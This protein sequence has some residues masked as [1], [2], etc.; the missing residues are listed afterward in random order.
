MTA[1]DKLKATLAP[2]PDTPEALACVTAG[3][4]VAVCQLVPPPHDEITAALLKGAGLGPPRRLVYQHAADLRHMIGKVP[5]PP[6]SA[7]G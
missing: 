2:L 5:V 3:D 1:L 4:V 7:E 6:A